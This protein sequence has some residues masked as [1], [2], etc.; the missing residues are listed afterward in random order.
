MMALYDGDGDYKRWMRMLLDRPVQTYNRMP[1]YMRLGTK[2][3]AVQQIL[4]FRLR[5]M[6]S[7]GRRIICR[8]CS[9]ELTHLHLLLCKAFR[10]R[11][12]TRPLL[13]EAVQMLNEVSRECGGG[14]YQ[15]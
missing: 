8:D 1:L 10:I 6:D 2:E 9:K 5:R 13:K 3:I 15:L 14:D 11:K 4:C 12:I 7:P